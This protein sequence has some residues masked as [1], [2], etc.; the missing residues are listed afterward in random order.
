MISTPYAMT[1]IGDSVSR[2]LLGLPVYDFKGITL[3]TGVKQNGVKKVY[4]ITVSNG[5]AVDVTG[6]DVV[7]T[8]SKR[9]T[10]GTWQRDDELKIGTKLQLH[11]HKGIVASRPLFDGSLH[12]AVSEDEA[13]LAGWLQSDGFVGQYPSGTNKSLTL[14]FETANNQEY[15]FVLGRVGKGFQND[16][17]NV[18]P[19]RVQSQDVNYRRVGMYGETLS[20]FVTKYNL[21]D[22]GTAMQAP[23]NLVA[24]SQEVIHEDVV[25][26]LQDDGV[27]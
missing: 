4:R 15:D 16:Q 11:A 3:V 14:E 9:R 10:V 13:E 8:S 23:R 22:R 24:A 25:R 2:H 19:V 7:L 27:V 26:L 12:D 6:D 20:P 21:L 5:V 18:T 1:H 17:Y